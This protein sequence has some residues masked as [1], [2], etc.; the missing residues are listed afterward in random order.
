MNEEMKTHFSRSEKW[1]GAGLLVIILSVAVPVWWVTDVHRREQQAREDLQLLVTA[2]EAFF[3]DYG[4]WPTPHMGTEN[5]MRYGEE[6]GNELVL[7]VL[8]AVDGPGNEGHRTNPNR[9]QYIKVSQGWRKRA[10]LDAAGAFR[11]PW[12]ISYQIVLDTDMN[13]VCTMAQ[14]IYPNQTEA[15]VVAWSYGSDREPGTAGDI[16]SWRELQR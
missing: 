9:I 1:I 10:G 3:V 16:V 4:Y 6:P 5:D 15:G 14:S 2:A 8:R 13:N 11:D 12:G 7:N